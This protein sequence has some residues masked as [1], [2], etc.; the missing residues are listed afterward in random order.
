MSRSLTGNSEARLMWVAG[1]SS[2]SVMCVIQ[3]TRAD[4]LETVTV[5]IL[6]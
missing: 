4:C 3:T 1:T 6:F 2:R 5:L